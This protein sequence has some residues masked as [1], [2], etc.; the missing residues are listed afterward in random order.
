MRRLVD[1]ESDPRAAEELLNQ[2]LVL[3][4]NQALAKGLLR[5][6]ADQSKIETI[7][8]ALAQPA[9]NRPAAN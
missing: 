8:R 1:Y 6:L 9:V 3:E 2:A 7:D 5:M 4:P